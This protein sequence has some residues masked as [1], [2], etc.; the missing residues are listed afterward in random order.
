MSAT[1]VQAGGGSV[2]VQ[3]YFQ[4]GSGYTYQDAGTMSLPIDGSFY[5]LTFPLSGVSDRTNVQFSGVNLA[6]HTNDITMNIDLVR[7]S[8]VPE[9]GAIA[10]VSIA[11][12]CA[13]VRRRVRER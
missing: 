1:D 11:A 2:D 12:C 8:M 6:S 7:Y 9:P 13:I 5:E 10:L 4:T 3:A